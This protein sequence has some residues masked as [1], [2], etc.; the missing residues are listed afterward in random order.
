M[1][2]TAKSTAKNESS[3]AAAKA[4]APPKPTGKDAISL[5]LADHREVGDYVDEYETTALQ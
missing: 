5:L 4:A 3:R 2:T 1:A